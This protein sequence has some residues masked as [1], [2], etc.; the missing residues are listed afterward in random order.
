MAPKRKAESDAV[1]E[2][3]APAPKSSSCVSIGGH[4]PAIGPLQNDEEKPLDLTVGVND[5]EDLMR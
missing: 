5:N 4:F 2:E 1:P 3:P